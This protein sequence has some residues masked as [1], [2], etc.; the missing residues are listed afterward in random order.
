MAQP[1]KGN[2]IS[3]GAESI[4]KA[5]EMFPSIPEDNQKD[6]DTVVWVLKI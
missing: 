5:L 1:R 2:S 4:S 3:F 6:I